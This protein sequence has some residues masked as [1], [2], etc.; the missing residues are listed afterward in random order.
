MKIK[1]I[2][3]DAGLK[4]SKNYNTVNSNFSMTVEVEPGEDV[5]EVRESM[6]NILWKMVND[7]LNKGMNHIDNLA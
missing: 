7:E 1:T 3:M 2:T 4:V 6:S 5:E